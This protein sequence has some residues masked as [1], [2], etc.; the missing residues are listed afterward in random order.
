MGFVQ[1]DFTK[2]KSYM[3]T[4]LGKIRSDGVVMGTSCPRS[5]K[6]TVYFVGGLFSENT[7]FFADVDYLKI[8]AYHL[9]VNFKEK[10]LT[11]TKQFKKGLIINDGYMY[12]ISADLN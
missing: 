3:Q 7:R 2:S 6:V 5:S 9:D 8:T 10:T 1:M 4:Y 12:T 11:A